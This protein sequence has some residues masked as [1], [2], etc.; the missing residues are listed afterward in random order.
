MSFYS[1]ASNLVTGDTNGSPDV[2]VHDRST[3]LTERVSVDS[4]GTEGNSDSYSYSTRYTK[5]TRY[6]VPLSLNVGVLFH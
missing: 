6:I 4:S 1:Y 5:E 3:G 2:F